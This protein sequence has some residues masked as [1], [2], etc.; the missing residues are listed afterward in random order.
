[1]RN[2]FPFAAAVWLP[3]Q[4][5]RQQLQ[6]G[7]AKAV[8][9]VQ[10]KQAAFV[11]VPAAEVHGWQ[12]KP[13]AACMMQSLPAAHIYI[14]CTAE[15]LP[16]MQKSSTAWISC[17]KTLSVPKAI[18]AV[19][20]QPLIV[21]QLLQMHIYGRGSTVAS[22]RSQKSAVQEHILRQN[23]HAPIASGQTVNCTNEALQIHI[24]VEGAAF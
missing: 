13:V 4:A 19:T 6:Q 14:I 18:L 15:I 7:G 11:L 3:G 24:W 10:D 16:G 1:M 17:R 20:G 8:V 22:C 23:H 2:R 21:T 9:Y 5:H 12:G